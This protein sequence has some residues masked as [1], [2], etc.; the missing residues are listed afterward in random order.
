MAAH[1]LDLMVLLVG[2][3]F[4]TARTRFSCWPSVCSMITVV[5]GIDL[6]C[7]KFIKDASDFEDGST[8]FG[9]DVRMGFFDRSLMPRTGVG[10][11]CCRLIMLDLDL[12][13]AAL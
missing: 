3:C 6:G 7:Q 5:D 12:D 8:G 4:C 1:C 10:W 2:H 13:E 11:R 9:W